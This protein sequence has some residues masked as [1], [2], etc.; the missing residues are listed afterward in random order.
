M[1]QPNITTSSGGGYSIE[2]FLYTCCF[3]YSDNG[4]RLTR[5][6]VG[7]RVNLREALSP[8]QG[9]WVRKERQKLFQTQIQLNDPIH[10]RLMNLPVSN[11]DFKDLPPLKAKRR[12][13]ACKGSALSRERT[14]QISMELLTPV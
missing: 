13:E 14:L 7:G 8:P 6:E 1:I 10:G 2:C 4:R 9:K 3:H 5:A 12:A 11:A